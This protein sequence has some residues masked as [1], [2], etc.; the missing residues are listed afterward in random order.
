MTYE[1]NTPEGPAVA[2]KYGN[3][4]LSDLMSCD[5]QEGSLRWMVRSVDK[6]PEIRNVAIWNKRFGGLPARRG[7]ARAAGF[8]WADG[9]AGGADAATHERDLCDP[10]P[11]AAAGAQVFAGVAGAAHAGAGG[12]QRRSVV[13]SCQQRAASI[14]GWQAPMPG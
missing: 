1:V 9:P 4:L 3:I 2:S 12:L 11:Y 7:A 14:P 10:A 13:G 5:L 8:F 6:Y